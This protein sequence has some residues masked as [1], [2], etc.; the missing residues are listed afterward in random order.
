MWQWDWTESQKKKLAK[1]RFL[2]KYSGVDAS[3]PKGQNEW[4][5]YRDLKSDVIKL[6]FVTW[7]ASWFYGH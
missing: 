3:P 7:N 6:K 5:I 4:M 2:K 1:R